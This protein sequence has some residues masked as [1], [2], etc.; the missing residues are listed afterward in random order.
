MK[1]TYKTYITL[2]NRYNV[3]KQSFETMLRLVLESRFNSP[4]RKRLVA[5]HVQSVE[6]DTE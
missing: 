1:Q 6:Q 2:D 4:K 5:V 3:T